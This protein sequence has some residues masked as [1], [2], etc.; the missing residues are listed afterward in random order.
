MSGLKEVRPRGHQVAQIHAA[1]RKWHIG[2]IMPLGP[3]GLEPG[4]LKL[5]LESSSQ[6]R[7]ML[8]AFALYLLPGAVEV[9]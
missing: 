3:A 4:V 8:A 5:E 7:L 2:R 1:Q 6:S 9:R